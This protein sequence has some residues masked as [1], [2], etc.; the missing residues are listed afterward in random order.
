MGRLISGKGHDRLVRAVARAAR[1]HPGIRLLVVGDGPMREDLAALVRAAD[2]SAIVEIVGFVDDVR[3]YIDACDVV[4]VPTESTLGEG[5]G[6]TALEAMAAAKPVV[7][8]A[9]GS[10]PEVVVDGS[11]GVVVEPSSTSA[12][13]DAIVALAGDRAR[14]SALGVAG[15]VRAQQDYGLDRMVDET[16]GVYEE[17]V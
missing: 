5:F 16:V 3:P 2:V 6:L 17:V 4:V 14:G 10:L 15:R 9:V 8:T 12:L 13:A 1:V 11:T 7:V